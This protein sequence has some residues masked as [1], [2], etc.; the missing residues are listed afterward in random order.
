VADPDTPTLSVATQSEWTNHSVPLQNMIN[1]R[2]I[3]AKSVTFE[4]PGVG[5]KT[6]TNS[7]VGTVASPCPRE[8]NATLAASQYTTSEM[9]EGVD[10]ITLTGKD[11]LG[12]EVLPA[13]KVTARVYVDKTAPVLA[14][15]SGSMTEQATLG[16][17]RPF[18][19]VKY[20]ASDGTE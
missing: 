20:S 17:T 14:A 9:P 12:N 2:G 16:T 3:G 18:Y 6:I 4:I 19:T 5:N 7:C 1:D 15:L 11:A 8:W 10:K 13:D